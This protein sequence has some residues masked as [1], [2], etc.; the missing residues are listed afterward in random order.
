MR[1]LTI[2]INRIEKYLHFL[3]LNHFNTLGG[4]IGIDF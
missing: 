4:K 3:S 2:E 1:D